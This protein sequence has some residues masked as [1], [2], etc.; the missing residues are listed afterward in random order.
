LR[1]YLNNALSGTAIRYDWYRSFLQWLVDGGH[2]T[3]FA[4]LVVFGEIL[5]GLGLILGG[6][7]A[8]AAFFGAFMNMAFML[9]GTTS[10]NPVMFTVSILIMIAWKVAGWYGLDRWLLVELGTPWQPG[11]LFAK[12]DKPQPQAG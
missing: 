11:R 10:S 7:T 4:K 5:V 12:G 1:G 2:Y 9:A 3:W 8:I 6:L